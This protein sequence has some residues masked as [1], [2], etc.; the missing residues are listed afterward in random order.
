MGKDKCRLCLGEAKQTPGKKT[1]ERNHHAQK[2]ST[3]PQPLSN[4][5]AAYSSLKRNTDFYQ[6]LKTYQVKPNQPIQK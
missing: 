6:Y 1:K 4:Q 2:D 5:H 3:I